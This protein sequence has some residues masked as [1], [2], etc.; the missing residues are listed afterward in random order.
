MF[1]GLVLISEPHNS[2]IYSYT[3]RK[4]FIN[5]VCGILGWANGL[6]QTVS[7]VLDN[8]ILANEQVDYLDGIILLLTTQSI[9]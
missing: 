8:K 6:P 3:C 2:E 1:E 9:Q 7:A 5:Q 4:D